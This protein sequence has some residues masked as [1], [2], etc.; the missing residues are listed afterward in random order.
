MGAQGGV[1]AYGALAGVSLTQAVFQAQAAEQQAKFQS[2]IAGINA[3]LAEGQAEDAITR[4]NSEAGRAINK[5]RRVA[6]SQRL[7][8]AAQG[9]NIA[10]GSPA[11]AARDTETMGAIDAMTIKNNA[12]REAYGYRMEA[13]N[14]R[15]NAR[16]GQIAARQEAF[17]T[18]LTG[19]VRAATYGYEAYEKYKSG[20]A[21]KKKAKGE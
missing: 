13:I 14:T 21:P 6:G 10:V 20:S 18:I 8:A 2:D 1:A 12:V 17:N 11:E 15:L 5:A 19:G 7:A 4:G 3:K 9:L 16:S